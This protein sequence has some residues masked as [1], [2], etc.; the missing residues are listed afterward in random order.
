MRGRHRA[1]TDL[2]VLDLATRDV[3][4]LVRRRAEGPGGARLSGAAWSPTGRRLLVARWTGRRAMNELL[5][6]GTRA[7]RVAALGIAGES[8]TWQPLAR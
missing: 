1:Y 8:P 2:R 6:V 4:R 5:V 3:R 7:G